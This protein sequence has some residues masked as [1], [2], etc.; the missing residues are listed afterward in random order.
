MVRGARRPGVEGRRAALAVLAAALVLPA[1]VDEVPADAGGEEIYVEVCARCHGA[2]LGGGIG[3]E[4]AAGSNASQQSDDYLR[5]AIEEGRG[6]MPS[7]DQTLQPDQV[8]RVIAYLRER[9]EG[10]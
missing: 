9:Q 4:L 10:S 1:C 6:R 7:F 2:D 3:P 5:T 8:D